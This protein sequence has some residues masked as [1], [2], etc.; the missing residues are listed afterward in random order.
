VGVP[1]GNYQVTPG[2]H[3]VR[4]AMVGTGT[5]ASSDIE[6]DVPAGGT[7]VLRTVGRGFANNATLGLALP[8]GARAQVTG[9]PIKSRFYKGPWINLKVES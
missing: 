8:A 3:R 5:S 2:A 4:I 1:D 9:E 6:I 7:R